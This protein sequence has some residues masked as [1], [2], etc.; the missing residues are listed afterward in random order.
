MSQTTRELRAA[1]GADQPGAGAPAP[2][3]P[4]LVEARAR[5][6][7]DRVAVVHGDEHL[8]Y[9]ELVRRVRALAAVL[10]EDYGVGRGVRV[11]LL[12]RR[13]VD[14]SVAIL[15]VLSAG[16]VCVPLDP[17]HP[18]NRL[19]YMLDHC[20][21]DL[22]VADVDVAPALAEG[23]RVADLRRA[24]VDARA[25]DSNPAPVDCAD[26]QVVYCLYTSGSTGRPKGV[27]LKQGGIRNVLAWARD[28]WQVGPGDGFLQ[29]ATFTFDISIAEQFLP[30]TTGAR[31]IVTAPGTE[32]SP[33]AIREAIVRHAATIVQ[34]TPS[35]LA[36]YLAV[37]GRDPLPGV[38]RCLAAGEPLKPALRDTFFAAVD[39]CT[40][41]NLYGPTENTI[42][43]TASDVPR[44]GPITVGY[45][46][47][48]TTLDIL[49]EQGQ[50]CAD[51]QVGEV[52]IG[53][54]GV[55]HGY[56]G[57]PELTA[58][59]YLDDAFRP[60]AR[61]FRSGD[62]GVLL[63]S[64]E[65]DVRGRRD[66]Q[67]KI[68]G[69]R[70]ELGEIES[71]LAALDGVRDAVVVDVEADPDGRRELVAYW[72]GAG[73]ARSLAEGLR[74]TLPGYMVP[75]RFIRMEQFPLTSTGKVQRAELPSPDLGFDPVSSYVAPQDALGAGVCA[76]LQESLG[77]G[78]VGLA[79]RFIDL[80]GDSL[81]AVRVTMLVQSR[82]GRTLEIEALL[83]NDTVGDL[84]GRLADAAAET[85]GG[86]Q[87]GPA[88]EWHPLASGQL[89]LWQLEQA[90]I[91]HPAYTEPVVFDVSG[92][93]DAYALRRAVHALVA[94]HEILRTGIDQVGDH[95][96][97]RVE[98]EV[99]L[100]WRHEVLA[101]P[102]QI[103]RRL[104]EFVA[105]DFDLAAGKVLRGILFERSAQEHV[106]ALALH[107]IVIDGWSLSILIDELI[108]AYNAYRDHGEPAFAPLPVQFKDYARWQQERLQSE[109]S[110]QARAY[111][112]A[113]LDGVERL[114]LPA[115]RPHPATRTYRGETIRTTLPATALDALKTLCHAERS[116]VYA[117][118]CAAVR[119][120]FYRY[121]GQR[122]F[123]LGTSA[124]IRSAPGLENQLGYY[125]NTLALRDEVA[126]GASFRSVLQ[127]TQSTLL[128]AMRH[129]EYPFNHVVSDLG[130]PTDS[131]RNPL[132]DVMV[133]VDPGWGDPAVAL[134]GA[135][136]AR[137]DAPNA[138]S[139]MDLTLFFKES[140]AGLQITAEYS[141]DVFDTD[142]IERMLDHI[143]T[144][145]S[146]AAADPRA[147][148][149]TLEVLPAGERDLVL[150]G[151]NATDHDYELETTVHALFE[152]QARLTPQR[153]ATVDEHRSLTYADLDARADALAWLLRDDHGVKAGDLV[154]LYLD[155]SVHS[156]VAILGVLKA[157]GAYLPINRKDPAERIAAVLADSES[158]VLL[159]DD[160]QAAAAIAGDL[161][162]I[163]VAD[164]RPARTDPPPP[165]SGAGDPAY[166][167]YTSGSTGVPNGVLIEHRSLINRLRWMIDDLG[168]GE[169]DV[170]LHKTPYVFDV[171][172]WELLVPGILGAR[173]VMLRPG[174]E[175]DPAAIRSAI[176][177][178]AVTV[179][180]FVPSM[181]DQ[182]LAGTDTDDDTDAD[183][184]P[185]GFGP[186]R[187]CVCSGEA[188]GDALAAR[189]HA[190][191]TGTST[192][193]HNYYG[194]TEASIDVTAL[195]VEPGR[196]VTIGRPVANTRIYVLD[197]A[198][199]PS[200]IGVDGELCIGG[201]QVARG[202][203]NRPEL[204]GQR[205]VADPFRPGGRM[206]R[207]GDLARW[208][209][210]GQ[211]AY[212]GRRDHQ[213]KLRGF[214]I[215]PGEIEKA[216][217]GEPGVDAAV[218]L[219][220]KSDTGVE[221]LCAYVAGPD[222]PDPDRL[223]AAARSR[224][225]EY[226]VPSQYVALD[227][228]PVTGNGKADRKALL[229]LGPHHTC[230][231]AQVAPRTDDERRLLEIWLTLLPETGAGVTDD[232]FTVGGNSLSALQLSS[233][234]AREFGLPFGLARVFAHRTVAD[235]AI[236]LSQVP[237]PEPGAQERRPLRRGPGAR[238]ALSYAQERM[239][240]L[241]M[242]EPTSSAYHISLFAKLTGALDPDALRGA[243]GDLVER[244]EMLRTTFAG[245][246]SGVYQTVRSDLPLPFELRDLGPLAGDE[247]ATEAED[248]LGRAARAA[249]DRP[250][251][252]ADEPPLRVVLLRTG[253]D[254]HHLLIVVHHL[255][256]DGWSMRL[257]LDELSA[258]YTRR[259]PP[260][261][262]GADRP[263]P[264]RP[265]AVQYVD[266]SD[267]LRDPANQAAID[268]DIAYWTERL[269]GFP[270]LTLP[271]DVP[272]TATPAT[273][274]IDAAND[275]LTSVDLAPAT[276]RG[277][278][279]LATATDST[280]FEIVLTALN[281]LLSRLAD[282]QDVV[283]GFPVTN[284]QS[285][286]LEPIIGLF[287]NTLALRTD[288]TGA[289]T[290]ADLLRRVREGV[291][292]AYEHQSAPFELLV[293]R[294][295]PE[296][297]LD[298]TPVFDVILNYQDESQA[299][300]AI[301]DAA[302]RFQDQHLD[303]RAKFALHFYV[304]ADAG[305]VKIDLAYRPDLFSA[306]RART[307][308][309]QLDALLAQS[310]KAPDQPAAAYSLALGTGADLSRPIARPLLPTVPDLVLGQAERRPAAPAVVQGSA[311]LDYGD[312]ADRVQALA[313]QLVAGGA[314]PRDVVAVT[315]PRGIGFTVALLAVL[316]SGA[317]VFPLDPA[318]PRG[319][320]DH[321][322]AIGRPVRA[323]IV[324]G[325][326]T[327]APDGAGP[328]ALDPALPADRI[329]ARTGRLLGPG[330]PSTVDLPP[331][332]DANP[333]YLFFTS[334]TTGAP[335]GVLGRHSGLSHFLTW[336][337]DTF[338]I[339]P[340]D[341]CAQT[342]S[343]SFDV[344]LRDTLLALVSG[345]TVVVPEPADESGGRALF[346]WLERQRVTVLHAVPTVFQSWLLDAA[347]GIRLAALRWL[348]CAGE[349]L[350]AALI[351]EFRGA[352]PD[353]A[354]IV[355][356]YGPTETTLAK[357][358]YQ[359]PHGPLPAALPVGRPLPQTQVLVLRDGV[360][361]GVGEPG[362]I[363]IRTPM[364]TFGYLD[365]ADATNAGFIPNPDR[366][367]PDDLLYRTGDLGRLRPDGLLEVL[368]RRDHQVKISGV[369]IQPA[370]VER[371]LLG[372][373]DVAACLVRAF[374]DP[375]GEAHLAAYVVAGP[376]D[377]ALAG[378]LRSFLSERLPRAMVPSHYVPLDRIP[379]TPNGKP[380]YAALPVPG[381][382][383]ASAPAPAELPSTDAQRVI[384]GL[385][386]EV[387]GCATPGVHDNFFE[388][389]G[390]SLRLL[391]LHSLLDHRF[392]AHIRV[393]QLFAHPTVVGQAALVETA[394]DGAETRQETEVV[395]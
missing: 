192:R 386:S 126:D 369:R 32:R 329:D 356:L 82:L 159:T 368:G 208:Q 39:G 362:E 206:Y 307:I 120:L 30:L 167:I 225:P 67:V 238:H 241:H 117:G 269:A 246:S 248:R 134:A 385:W 69:F 118:L 63:P 103:D 286:E 20:G 74:R 119:V 10:R 193:L 92:P 250:F 113:R 361:C 337:R 391:R 91:P 130:R 78:R 131:D 8:T 65:L 392:P 15:A 289:P 253:A 88:A 395:F 138:H 350:K 111:W 228:L 390:T 293:E 351:E 115:D 311:V 323:V 322:L 231:Q 212:Q 172:V 317:T 75:S 158:R 340:Q 129:A 170:F 255:A 16:G 393:A 156:I 53:G 19:Q 379:T 127:A 164:P 6:H 116:T 274:R 24:D 41:T 229:K 359:V 318:L 363:V 37:A 352:F 291:R 209:P 180:H 105:L 202:Y 108:T 287:L 7:P 87:P 232:F 376:D 226:M 109:S 300:L 80:G 247:P 328:D 51:G 124:V 94:R 68:R 215:E 366:D 141:T 136:L 181:L 182:Y 251:A 381:L 128:D 374:T 319:R 72:I 281:L 179:V 345:G 99:E 18:E 278:R 145:L 382:G 339:T 47:P 96:M 25:A 44:T 12:L 342:T 155:R 5:A 83:R 271:T 346:D 308:L 301:G 35:G 143:G 296:R 252:L 324:Q 373:P 77:T 210:D 142:R 389:G 22:V 378:R 383:R 196:P 93:L 275:G 277:L 38:S 73:D 195:D 114:Q 64:G 343:A 17:G 102:A 341:R 218:V 294:L 302:V 36:T 183:A 100:D 262:P 326:G 290:F 146:S 299:R 309:A 52:F 112:S 211:I 191:V 147:S 200:P 220:R 297:R 221:Y 295:N 1:A 237:R 149:D 26:D 33:A 330:L 199:R 304:F 188:L 316:R 325:D 198:G 190:A 377:P 321:L 185:G 28:F 279:D 285:V 27:L 333:A 57:L 266:Y 106:F 11:P 283:I 216:L 303:V 84:I 261:G 388:L 372:H 265:L 240:F 121:T 353:S 375:R 358:A 23:R 305:A 9:A 214:R 259:R 306:D 235:Q 242:L 201:V 150:A 161:A 90:G 254:E 224:L 222:V 85:S 264:P 144:L 245:D 60:G 4:Q 313:R 95:A 233:R 348:F 371:A 176:D 137:R 205:F 334:G 219:L 203:R 267:S 197:P 244:H 260:A 165:S 21:A 223:R 98:P 249:V 71:A 186:V 45:P 154:A 365:D 66:Y 314:R 364:R 174:G 270:T 280:P 360:P 171:S 310:T 166:C 338:G 89:G 101:D 151:F 268:A 178:H 243:V 148:V 49:D 331:I 3:I 273:G 29:K 257:L 40:L 332:D 207:T 394:P 227:A 133:M 276:A 125:V 344:M 175:G 157:G 177:R 187:H 387:L 135:Q 217:R 354:E 315:G 81:K 312:L 213:V 61:T 347:P 86:P 320:R 76:I 50:R 13:N 384:A 123:T 42:Y 153:V 256:A 288:L 263:E 70:V 298:H 59:R 14:M 31:L 189:F 258:S 230:G 335:R 104:A 2:S 327:Q 54:V 56:L 46:L 110:A 349:P 336:Q 43:A 62:L 239:W 55:S 122:D 162:V 107:H 58:E 272:A 184:A 152:Q 204:T 292:E 168:L 160:P 132:F 140:E 370:E 357:F 194:P 163:D 169:D 79:D 48:G 97:Q 284:R 380:D 139:K 282:Q 173:Q 236:A 355:N 34:F 367:D 234:I